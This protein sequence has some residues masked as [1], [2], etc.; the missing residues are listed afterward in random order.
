VSF[1]ETL[2]ILEVENLV[3]KSTDV[4]PEDIWYTKEEL[5]EIR[6]QCKK[7]ALETERTD[8]ILERGLEH[9][10]P[11]GSPHHSKCRRTSKNIV[12]LEQANEILEHGF[13]FHTDQLANEYRRASEISRIQARSRGCKDAVRA[14]GDLTSKDVVVL[15]S[16]NMRNSSQLN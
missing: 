15:S 5:R 7:Q 4:V 10:V 11:R 14:W 3:E 2:D 9:M 16:N 8:G 12:F 1:Q 13:L 6:S